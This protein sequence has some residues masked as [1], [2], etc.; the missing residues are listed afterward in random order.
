MSLAECQLVGGAFFDHLADLRADEAGAVLRAVRG[1]ALARDSVAERQAVPAGALPAGRA[2][3]EQ[4]R[5][6][7]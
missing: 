4:R 6:G 3:D 2:S 7:A 5:R 1:G